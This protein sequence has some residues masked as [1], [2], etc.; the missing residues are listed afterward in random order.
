VKS[1]YAR[2]ESV[3][4]L[5]LSVAVPALSAWAQSSDASASNSPAQL[6]ALVVVGQEIPPTGVTIVAPTPGLQLGASD[7]ASLP[8]EVPG[9]AVARNRPLTGIV[10]LRGLSDDRV[11]V[12]VNGMEITPACPNHM[13]PPLLYIAPS[14][15]HSLT[16]IPGITPVSLGGDNIGGMVLAEPKP[17]A[18]ATTPH[19]LFT[20][21]LGSF[22]RSS[23]DGVGVNGGFTLANQ[24]WSG[25]YDGSWQT[26]DDL[27]FP[28]GRVLDSG[29][30]EYQQHEGRIATQIPNGILDVY[31]G[32]SRIRD[33]GTPAQ[34]MDMIKDDGWNIG[35]GLRGDYSFGELD[36]RIGSISADHVMDNFSLRSLTSM[37]GMMAAPFTAPS[38]S[39]DLSGSIG[40]TIPHDSDIFRTGLD[41][42][43]SRF[44]AFEKDLSDGTAQEDI[45]NATRSR[46]GVYFEWQRNWSAQWTTLAGLRSDT[47]W[48]DADNI[49]Q[50]YP[51]SAADAAAFNSRPH[52]ATN[53]NLDA[54]AS[55]RFTPDNHQ[56]YELAFARKTRS[57][58]ILE[59][60]IYPFFAA[61]SGNS[62]GHNYVG[63][64]DSSPK[65]HT[66]SRSLVTGMEMPGASE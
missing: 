31:G 20:G 53:V 18:F 2:Y 26:A 25:S 46:V 66:K 11:G 49:Q 23:N 43:W 50:F 35:T 13:D 38:Q 62:D 12:L 33:A 14:Q 39:D 9:A 40:L 27:R 47:V 24:S 29:F 41:F 65:F 7:T 42:H 51:D 22:Y 61:L 17:S 59:R 30:G 6:P 28:G 57:P 1:Q 10:Q 63:N 52:Q 58:S 37:G 21:E 60:H 5:A 45:N 3:L 36:A 44:D 32:V 48:S 4:L 54:M 15:L 19:P 8:E 55:I 16:V 64:L 56:S 34:P